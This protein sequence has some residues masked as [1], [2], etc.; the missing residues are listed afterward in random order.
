MEKLSNETVQKLTNQLDNLNFNIEQLNDS[1][2]RK[3][4][5]SNWSYAEI[6]GSIASSLI[7]M[8]SIENNKLNQQ[9]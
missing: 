3:D 5:F 6:F 7:K 1:L 9:K 8:N 2:N 4:D